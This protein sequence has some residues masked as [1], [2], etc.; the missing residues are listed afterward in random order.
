M[1]EL[2]I[3]NQI[4][5]SFRL[6]L[7]THFLWKSRQM[8]G[9]LLL[10][11]LSKNMWTYQGFFLVTFKFY[12]FG[13]WF[14]YNHWVEVCYFIPLVRVSFIDVG[15][16]FS[17]KN[18]NFSFLRQVFQYCLLGLKECQ[19]RFAS[20]FQLKM[21]HIHFLQEEFSVEFIF[22]G[23]KSPPPIL[24]K[25]IYIYIYIYISMLYV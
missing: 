5:L 10:L 9:L 25:Y 20:R 15:S 24:Y 6:L 1:E 11:V 19:L 17:I 21:F 2:L 23:W 3:S 13:L 18:L 22:E 8:W 12:T 4:N 14:N 16:G 7:F